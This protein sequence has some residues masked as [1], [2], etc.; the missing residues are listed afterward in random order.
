[1]EIIG[2]NVLVQHSERGSDMA[3]I[4]KYFAAFKH[5]APSDLEY[6]LEEMASDGFILAPLSQSGLFCFKFAE[7]KGERVKYVVDVTGLQKHLYMK[8]L[9][10]KGWEYMGQVLNCHIWKMTYEGSDRPEDFADHSCIRKHCIRMG[11]VFIILALLML[12]LFGGYLFLIYKEHA[13][14]V[15]EKHD[16]IYGILAGVQIP[17]TAIFAILAAK[18]FKE[19]GRRKQN[20]ERAAAFK[21]ARK[22]EEEREEYYEEA[23]DNY[24]D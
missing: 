17:F 24:E 4:N 8:T 6:Y 15:P 2:Y 7:E 10:D 18:L 16:L 12:L 21:R 14:A 23:G 5:I 19:A 3:L 20:I 13:V 9:I 1:M 11:I 22:A